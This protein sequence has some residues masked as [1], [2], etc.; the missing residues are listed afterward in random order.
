MGL[1]SNRNYVKYWLSRA[2]AVTG[3]QITY[4]SFPLVALAVADSALS[5]AL[6]TVATYAT[7]FLASIPAGYLADRVNRK[8]LMVSADVGAGAAFGLTGWL[9][10]SG[11][12]GVGGLIVSAIVVSFCG[13]VYGAT[14]T[15]A[16][17]SIVGQGLLARAVAANE[18][19]DSFLALIGPLAGAAVFVV[20]SSAPFFINS[21]AFILSAVLIATIQASSTGRIQTARSPGAIFA[22]LRRVR[23]DPVLWTTLAL[24]A[25]LGL[26]LTT[27]FFAAAVLFGRDANATQFGVVVAAQAAGLFV[28]SMFAERLSNRL[29]LRTIM[30][31]LGGLW[32]VAC[33]TTALATNVIATSVA[34]ALVWSVVPSQRASYQSY[35]AASVPEDERGRVAATAQLFSATVSPLGVLLAGY[36]T[37]AHGARSAFVTA[38]SIAAVAT[39]TYVIATRRRP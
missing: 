17:P 23:R 29:P 19:R 8:A 34:L 20:S 14:A 5:A 2:F 1:A 35:V 7:P 38:A 27:N 13:S 32:F 3:S 21:A 26:V 30:L 6:V 33:T 39:I 11:H 16:L 22:G 12:L 15:A 36:L 37:Q 9:L 24:I 31:I 28:G 25:M 4:V 18:A 10:A